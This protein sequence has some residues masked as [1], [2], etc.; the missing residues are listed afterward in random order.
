MAHKFV[1]KNRGAPSSGFMMR[2]LTHPFRSIPLHLSLSQTGKTQEGGTFRSSE[3]TMFQK[4]SLSVPQIRRKETHGYLGGGAVQRLEKWVPSIG[5]S[6]MRAILFTGAYRSRYRELHLLEAASVKYC[7]SRLERNDGRAVVDVAS[8]R[9]G[10]EY[11][12]L[13]CRLLCRLANLIDRPSNARKS[14]GLGTYLRSCRLTAVYRDKITEKS[15]LT[16]EAIAK[17]NF[18]QHLDLEERRKPGRGIWLR[19]QLIV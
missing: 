9:P 1:L 2:K 7:S 15:G 16:E 18:I 8:I 10:P 12:K 11:H 3:A 14:W 17:E 19:L 5:C 6:P 13:I 4:V